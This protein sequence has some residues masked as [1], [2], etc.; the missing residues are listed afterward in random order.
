[1]QL[2]RRDLLRWGIMLG[3]GA[4]LSGGRRLSQAAN[5]PESP[6]TRPF[7]VELTKAN[8]GIPETA[9][10]VRP[11]ATQAD[12][13]DCVNVEGATALHVPG[14][15]AAPAKTRLFPLPERDTQPA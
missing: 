10:P 13:A 7:V 5:L 3:G 2:T 11:L 15:R 1:M 12:P 14:P 4:A 6:P 8:G 9:H